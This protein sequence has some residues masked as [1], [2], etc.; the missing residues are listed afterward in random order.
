MHHAEELKAV[1]SHIEDFMIDEADAA[2][3]DDQAHEAVED[4]VH[5]VD[6]RPFGY[7]EKIGCLLALATVIIIEHYGVSITCGDC[8]LLNLILLGVVA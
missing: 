2:A 5:L 3:R 1:K 7:V 4:C 6:V 8:C